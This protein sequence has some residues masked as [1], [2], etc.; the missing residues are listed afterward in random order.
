[1]PLGYQK[2]VVS[3]SFRRKKV[4]PNCGNDDFHIAESKFSWLTGQTNICNKCGYKFKKP[5]LEKVRHK[6][7]HIKENK[8][9][10][11]H[12]RHR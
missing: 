11:K 10:H 1:M 12:H 3:E 2:D 6:E 8:Y 7:K 5:E 9:H 4:C